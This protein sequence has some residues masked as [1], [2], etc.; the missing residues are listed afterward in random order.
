MALMRS[1]A[2]GLTV[3]TDLGDLPLDA[4]FEAGL[5]T[6]VG[7]V[8]GE[9]VLRIAAFRAARRRYSRFSGRSFS[10]AAVSGRG[11]E[12]LAQTVEHLHRLDADATEDGVVLEGVDTDLGL[13]K[14]LDEVEEVFGE[15]GLEGDDEL[16][17]VET[18][19][20]GGVELDAGVHEADADVLVHEALALGGREE[21]PG[22]GLPE[23]VDED[24]LLAAGTDGSAAFAFALV[25]AVDGVL[26]ALGHGEEAV[27][28]G[29]VAAEG[30]GE[31]LGAHAV[32]LVDC[33][34]D[35][36]DAHVYIAA[37]SDSGIRDGEEFAGLVP[38]GEDV[39]EG[40]LVGSLFF[41]G[42]AAPLGH[43]FVEAEADN[44][45]LD[46]R[47]TV[48]GGRAV[49]AGLGTCGSGGFCGDGGD[50]GRSGYSFRHSFMLTKVLRGRRGP[51]RTARVRAVVL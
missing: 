42:E 50:C 15:V 30:S 47:G 7:R 22:A 28:G 8:S 40:L 32:E 19:G 39:D 5:R 21:I 6:V 45:A 48:G 38:L 3:L 17:V 51:A 10:Q 12:V 16:L 49:G 44:L 27:R 33:V 14:L 24:V 1:G 11:P 23:G 36:P 9:K 41:G 31:E 18:E 20:V 2:R 35:G 4:R 37:G 43:E 26:R 25:L 34:A 13:P 29:E 46:G